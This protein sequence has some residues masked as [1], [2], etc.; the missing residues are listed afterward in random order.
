MIQIFSDNRQINRRNTVTCAV[1]DRRRR[2]R[3]HL[4]I[5]ALIIRRQRTDEH[6][7][8]KFKLVIE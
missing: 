3:R 5:P 4:P 8:L 2:R 1:Q 6:V 7:N